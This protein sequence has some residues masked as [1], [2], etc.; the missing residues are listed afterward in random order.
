MRRRAAPLRPCGQHGECGPGRR[1]PGLR[2]E[3]RA[4]RLWSSR[5]HPAPGAVPRALAG[6]CCV[7]S[8]VESPELSL[9]WKYCQLLSLDVKRLGVPACEGVP[10]GCWGL[11]QAG[12]GPGISG[13]KGSSPRALPTSHKPLLGLIAAAVVWLFILSEVGTE[14]CFQPCHL[15][16]SLV[17]GWA[18]SEAARCVYVKMQ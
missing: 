17:S 15:L 3:N 11:P 14:V 12:S 1:D 2:G 8:G 10:A 5:V 4:G 9:N 7:P 13:A 16:Q 6:V 18:W